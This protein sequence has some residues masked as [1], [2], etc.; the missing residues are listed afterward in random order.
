MAIIGNDLGTSDP[1]AKVL[2]N[3][4]S[5]CPAG[6]IAIRIAKP[7]VSGRYSYH[8]YREIDLEE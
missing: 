7:D 1:A 2:R 3:I 6:V 4:R 5:S 8:H